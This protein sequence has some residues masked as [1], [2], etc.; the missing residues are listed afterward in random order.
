MISDDEVEEEPPAI[1]PALVWNFDEQWFGDSD[2]IL[3]PE[4]IV[5][6]ITEESDDDLPELLE[7]TSS[8]DEDSIMATTGAPATM[9]S[10]GIAQAAG[11][12]V[13]RLMGWLAPAP[14]MMTDTGA[15]FHT[16]NV[17]I[18]QV[19]SN[20]GMIRTNVADTGTYVSNRMRRNII[21]NEVYADDVVWWDGP[22][23]ERGES[24]AQA[25]SEMVEII[26]AQA[27]RE[28]EANREMVEIIMGEQF[29]DSLFSL[30]PG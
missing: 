13:R 22:A 30:Q 28:M 15:A 3:E 24:T 2:A 8:E 5:G 17:T 21:D 10:G 18:R 16:M 9:G 14:P 4:E 1:L 25:S 19:D 20:H 7:D 29:S 11:R 12:A 27:N 6:E 26:T 23:V